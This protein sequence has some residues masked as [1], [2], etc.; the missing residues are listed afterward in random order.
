GGER[1]L[2]DRY[3]DAF[4][5][6]PALV[7]MPTQAEVVKTETFAPIL[8][9]MTYE[10]FEQAIALHNGV[11][12]GLSSS[13]FTMNIKEAERFTAASGSDCGI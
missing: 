10:T 9:V 3:K 11:P 1:V 8:Y 2:A 6:T 4:Y 5:V 12:Q 7:E 13:I